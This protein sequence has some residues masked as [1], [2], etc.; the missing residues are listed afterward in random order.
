MIPFNGCLGVIK[1]RVVT[2]RAFSEKKSGKKPLFHYIYINYALYE[3][4]LAFV[5]LLAIFPTKKAVNF[6]AN[7]FGAEV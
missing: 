7:D 1:A 6:P 3:I 5:L 4:P 2:A